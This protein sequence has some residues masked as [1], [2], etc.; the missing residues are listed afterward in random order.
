M[1]QGSSA[2]T[3]RDSIRVV[4]E[5]SEHGAAFFGR[6]L[7][8]RIELEDVQPQDNFR[9]KAKKGGDIGGQWEVLLIHFEFFPMNPLLENA[10]PPP[11][12]RATSDL[13][14]VRAHTCSSPLPQGVEARCA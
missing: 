9:L 4:R 14:V 7:K 13:T 1:R 3:H 10:F 11:G 5:L 6:S 12:P 2:C 8:V